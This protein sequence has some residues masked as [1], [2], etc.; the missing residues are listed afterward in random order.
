MTLLAL[1]SP[2]PFFPD[3][4]GQ[5]CDG[6]HLYFGTSGG[7][8][9]TSP[10]TVYWDAAGTQ[11]AAQPIEL[12][13]GYVTRYGRPAFVYTPSTDYSVT[14]RDRKGKVV[15]YAPSSIGVSMALAIQGLRDDLASSASASV[16][17]GMVGY[18][19]SRAYAAGTVGAKLKQTICVD[20]APFNAVGDGVA[21]DHNAIEAAQTALAAL[22]GGTLL[23]SPG[24]TYRIGSALAMHNGFT[25]E[26]S[27]RSTSDSNGASMG[28]RIVSSA[29]DIFVNSG[30]ICAGVVFRN[31]WLESQSGGG[32]IFNWTGAGLT[33]KVEVDGCMLFQKNAAKSVVNGT[34]ASGVFSIWMHD[35]EF[36]YMVANSVPAIN[37]VSPTV[38]SI[39]IDRFWSICSSGATSG[40][41]AIW[42]ESTNA[43]GAALNVALRQGVFE[44]C[45]GGAVNFLSVQNSTIEDCG[46]Y[47]L[48]VTPNKPLFNCAKGATGPASSD[49]SFKRLRSTV[50]VSGTA[51]LRIDMSVGGQSG[52]LVEQCTLN[53]YDGV[54]PNGAGAMHIANTIFNYA[55]AAYTE[56]GA[57]A[58]NDLRWVSQSGSGKTYALWNGVPG[59]GE[60]YLHIYQAGAYAGA[61]SPSGILQWGGTIVAPAFYVAQSG[62]LNTKS[63]IM[64]GTPAGA[65]QSAS[66]IYAGTGAPN[67][68]D[69]NNGDFYF[70][71]DGGAGTTI[72]QRRAGAW[73]GIV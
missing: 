70:R 41:Y 56:L 13:N 52:F 1:T 20:D 58:T 39:V 18:D 64:P 50:G 44:V 68:A 19:R 32:H 34:C 38:N 67:N 27:G 61:I 35:F 12:I 7:N 28:A 23:F 6:G 22:G 73:V 29:S 60:G 66:G 16:G 11:P 46:I 30:T 42:I 72:Y 25:Y 37:I 15:F 63:R 24:K 45:G 65:D 26:G 14:L 51:D 48:L 31:L 36:Y 9:E 49:C 4:R 40:T 8:P 53:Y 62:A 69:G 10:V 43:G 21:D 54:S 55:N 33:A 3:L 71:S 47:D 59:N 57:S 17:A 5:P 2:F